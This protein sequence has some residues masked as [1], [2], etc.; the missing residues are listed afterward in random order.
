[1]AVVAVSLLALLATYCYRVPSV[2]A[3]PDRKEGEEGEWPMRR[4]YRLEDFLWTGSGDGAL[5]PG[6]GQGP[7]ASGAHAPAT[8]TV[9]RTTTVLTTVFPTS[10]PTLVVVVVTSS[11]VVSPP[12][13]SIRPTPTLAPGGP[14]SSAP[15]PPP[16]PPPAPTEPDPGWTAEQRYWLL[17]VVKQPPG[18]PPPTLR[19]LEARLARLYRI[20]FDRQQERHLGLGNASAPAPAGRLRRAP[21]G[22]VSVR[23]LEA[24]P[25]AGDDAPLRL[26]YAVSVGGRP[27]PAVAAAYDMRLLSDAEVSAEL[28]MPVLTKAEPFLKPAAE[29]LV[30]DTW[31]LAGAAAAAACLL[32]LFAVLLAL[33]MGKRKRGK[34]RVVSDAQAPGAGGADNRAFVDSEGAQRTEERAEE[35]G[36]RR[37]SPRL[38]GVAPPPGPP[39]PVAAS[40]REEQTQ[41]PRRPASG[42]SG[43]SSG[44]C[45]S[46]RASLVRRRAQPAH[47]HR[48]HR[49]HHDQ[50][51]RRRQAQEQ[52]QQAVEG[53]AKKRPRPA[54]TSVEEPE[55]ED[56]ADGGARPVGDEAA[57]DV[58]EDLPAQLVRISSAV[59]PNSFLSMP[60]IK[61]FPRGANIP[62]PLARVLEPVSV[63]HLDCDAMGGVAPGAA[64][65]LARHGSTGGGDP[66]VVGPLVWQLH[67]RQLQ[68]QQQQHQH[69]GT[70]ENTDTEEIP[71]EITQP[72]TAGS[73]VGHMRRRFHELLDDAFSLFGS[74]SESPGLEDGTSS[75]P[76]LHRV[77]SAIVRPVGGPPG[78]SAQRPHT[79]ELRRPATASTPL[80]AAARPRGAWGTVEHSP[81]SSAGRSR[82]L[83]AGPFHRPRLPTAPEVDCALVL[84]DSRLA[85]SD[86]AVPLI[87]AIKEELQKFSDSAQPPVTLPGSTSSK[88]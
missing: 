9:F 65:R 31:L 6:P 71:E 77:H 36:R 1:M 22:P 30:G 66:G 61:A 74:R 4:A 87:A 73:N 44:A 58:P 7:A 80:T 37:P 16:P 76:M 23:L 10:T 43:S 63:R 49:H 2:L 27:V 70:E 57:A 12:A 38:P 86:P 84:C 72:E 83:S 40:V 42:S 55:A 34:R 25:L 13:T 33:G 46:A 41:T 47:H 39:P 17:T 24:A 56:M 54:A 51:H 48:K 81:L 59:S 60:S 20:A 88:T 45:S 19:E 21:A 52:Q 3:I 68:Q 50:H 64:R 29:P 5:P 35:S 79:T 82:P 75:P 11:P 28:G 14:S 85:P 15:P 8:T 26:V 67:C 62:E 32:L 53:A 78:V 69:G 18:R